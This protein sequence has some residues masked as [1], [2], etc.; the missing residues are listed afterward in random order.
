[1]TTKAKAPKGKKPAAAAESAKKH[2][3]SKPPS[4]PFLQQ[5]PSNPWRSG[6]GAPRKGGR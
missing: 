3:P 1:M 6:A 5:H 4:N 2:P